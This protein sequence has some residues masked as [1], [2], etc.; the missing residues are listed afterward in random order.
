M[1]DQPDTQELTQAAFLLRLSARPVILAGGGVVAAGAQQELAQVAQRL[2]APVVTTWNGKAS[3]PDDNEYSA[4]ALFGGPEA[5]E[6]LESADTVFALGT[7]FDAGPGSAPLDLPAQ[8]I[9]VDSDPDQIG[10]KYPLRLGIAG[11][12]KVV[13]TG[14]LSALQ[15]PNPLKGVADRTSVADG[16]R[17]GPVRAGQL[18]AT[19]SRRATSE[20]PDQMAALQ[21][22]RRALPADTVVLH[23]HSGSSAWFH[24]FFAVPQAGAWL[25]STETAFPVA[26]AA[27]AAGGAPGAM[28]CFCDEDELIPH[29][30]E[31]EGLEEPG[32]LV[33]V[34][35][36]DR[37]DAGIESDLV[38]ASKET[39]LTI[40]VTSGLGELG[41]AL[42]RA[43]TSATHT[44]IESDVRW[45]SPA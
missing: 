9:Q 5:R 29:L 8:M 1:T 12:A 38:E 16:D 11:D 25:A 3:I 4:G 21:T 7:T 34:V 26:E 33:F 28:V 37:S 13:L 20:G 42:A 41:A 39:G 15:A 36:T 14:I 43:A 22:I 31:L 27:A 35:F 2:D 23:R 45:T 6:A 17:T 40:V 30:T 32:D 24:P 10:R 19:A 18:R 44:I